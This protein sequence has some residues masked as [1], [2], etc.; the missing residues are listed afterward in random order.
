MLS[1]RIPFKIEILGKTIIQEKLKVKNYGDFR[2][3][4][5]DRRLPGLFEWIEQNEI[6]RELIEKE[7]EEYD[8]VRL[9]VA[10]LVYGFETLVC[11]R[12]RAYFEEIM[13]A[14]KPGKM[15]ISNA[16]I[17]EKFYTEYP[18]FG[19]E[20]NLIRCLRNAFS[21]NQ[22]PPKDEFKDVAANK[23]LGIA[24][25]L[26]KLAKDKIENYMLTLQ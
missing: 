22:Y 8:N 19:V 24:K 20:N 11:N 2:R 6:E 4:M 16:E 9:E 18:D 1:R 23:V 7:L 3:F 14:R 13:A 21:H 25:F 12:Y 10:N 5:K 17:L 26:G 15:C